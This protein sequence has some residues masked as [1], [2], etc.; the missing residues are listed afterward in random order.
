MARSSIHDLGR[1]LL[2]MLA[3]LLAGIALAGGRPSDLQVEALAPVWGD[4]PL[5][6]LP[7]FPQAWR[8]QPAHLRWDTG[9]HWWRLRLT[10]PRAAGDPDPWI[11]RLREPYD[12]VVTVYL[13]P[14]DTARVL[15]LYD[16]ALRQPGSRLGLA[17]PLQPAQRTGWIYLHIDWKRYQPIALQAMPQAAYLAADLDHI[18]LLYSLLS[19]MLAL[20]ALTALFA[21]AMQRQILVLFSLWVL[22]SAVY[23]LGMSGEIASLLPGL[24]RW[25]TPLMLATAAAHIGLLAAYLFVYRFLALPR[26]FPRA[27]RIYRGLL[28]CGVL[29][30]VPSMASHL[31]P[32]FAAT[33][34]VL[35]LALSLMVLALSAW[36]ARQGDPQGWFFL[37]GWGAVTLVQVLRAVFFLLHAGT[38]SWLALLHPAADATGALVLAV[39]VARAARYA[40]REMRHA[41]AH[42]RTDPLT[43]LANR[44]ELDAALPA[45][46]A[47][48]TREHQ[49]ISVLFLDL[50]H[51]KSINDRHGHAVGDLCLI[52]TARI[53][54][55][56]V[57]A[58]DLLARYGGEEFVLI[59]TGADAGT[60]FAVGEALRTAVQRHGHTIQGHTLK[61][62]VSVG[63]AT[64]VAGESADALLQRADMA[65]YQAKAE[66]RNRCVIAPLSS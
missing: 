13:P 27:A 30:I 4:P 62:T 32:A 7:H 16:P 19:G 20:A 22:C 24:S 2:L 51:F 41:R 45:C 26:H 37:I 47:S 28:W 56:H 21:F 17:V 63:I 46:L 65:L 31:A 12:N 15:S 40:E 10:D 57:R 43:G 58:H 9:S 61:L 44:A 3:V 18:R 60:A 6:R 48:A 39:A 33:L 34:N 50:D 36:R 54:R 52:E 66:G 59:L 11:L 42:A 64:H 38:P 5:H 53:L 35:L 23:H 8:S 29:L 49:P 55:Q 14:A 1:R 25:L